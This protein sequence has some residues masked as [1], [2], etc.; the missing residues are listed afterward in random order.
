MKTRSAGRN[1]GRPAIEDAM[2]LGVPAVAALVLL[3][4]LRAHQEHRDELAAQYLVIRRQGAA[5]R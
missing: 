5:D 4:D 2:M 1:T 3:H